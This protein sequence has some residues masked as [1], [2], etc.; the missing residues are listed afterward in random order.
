MLSPEELTRLESYLSRVLAAGAPVRI[1]SAP[2][3]AGGA[4]R[5]TYSLEAIID[6]AKRGLILRRDPPDSL[7]DTE[8]ALEFAAY[9]SVQGRDIPAPRPLALVTDETVLG[10]PFFVME[11]IDNAVAGSP[12]NVNSFGD[13]AGAIGR[14]FF[15][16]LGRIAAID[17]FATELAAVTRAPPAQ[18][19]WKRELDH[20]AGV[21]AADS[22][23]PQPIAQA[24]IRRLRKNPPPAPRRLSI[25]HG[26]YRIGN[27]LHDGRGA[28]KAVLDW[29]MAHIGDPLED[30][31]WALD[32]LWALAR[33]DLAAGLVPMEEAIAL[34]EKHSGL[35]FDAERFRWWSLF[36]SLKGLAIWISS[37]KAYDAGVNTDPVLGFSGWYCMTRHNKILADRLAAA[38]RGSLG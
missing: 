17:P 27:F 2:R 32:P 18:E 30:L 16:I 35:E 5:Q 37:A 3:I 38:A 29:E 23:E 22:L 9:Q 13:H 6:G 25:V 12:F 7:I 28:I 19:C 11:R 4:S 31:A 34:W 36:A 26:D 15:S 21:I 10:A 24:A 8:R 1:L 14:E 33:K 20:W